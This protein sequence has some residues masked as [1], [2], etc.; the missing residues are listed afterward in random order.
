MGSCVDL[1]TV[2]VLF[3]GIILGEVDRLK[4]RLWSHFVVKFQPLFIWI[5]FFLV[6]SH[7]YWYFLEEIWLRLISPQ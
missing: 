5:Y 3:V 2:L 6:F 7:C 4:T 1:R